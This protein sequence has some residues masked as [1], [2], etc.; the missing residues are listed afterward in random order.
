MQ[1]SGIMI[2]SDNPKALG[3]FYTKIFGEPGM[4]DNEWYGFGIGDSNL[5][6]GRHSDVHGKNDT[7]G[8]IMFNVATSDVQGEFARIKE[9][10]AEVI[11]EPYQ[12]GEDDGDMWIATF[13]DPDGNYFQIAT[14][15]KP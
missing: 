5:M 12:P 10:G 1:L 3:E 7:P 11:A 2:G 6:V 13:A 8:R 4:Q 14:P 9:T 15:W